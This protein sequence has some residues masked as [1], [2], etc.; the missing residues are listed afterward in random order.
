MAGELTKFLEEREDAYVGLEALLARAERGGL[1]TFSRDELVQLGHLYRLAAAD[2]ARA[3]Y[4]LKSP[5]LSEYLNELVG[6]A[7]H[8]I[9]RRRTPILKSVL[10][11]VARDF[12]ATVRR[13]SGPIL[14]AVTLFVGS[15]LVG[16]MA[17]LA[18]PEW[19]Q[20]V[21]QQPELK[22]IEQSLEREP[23]GLASAIEEDMMP[24][25]S[26]FIISNNVRVS[27]VAAA[28]GI[29]F[30]L[31]TLLAL[32][33]NGF[34]LGVVAVMFL[35]RGGE[36]QLYFFSGV[37]PHGVL[38]LPAICIAGGIGFLLARGLL[39]PGRLSR[40]DAIRR[41]SKNAMKLLGGV[42]LTLVLAGLIE[43]FITPLRAEWVPPAV[44]I[45]LA[46]LLF[47]AFM[48]Y[49][50]RAGYRPEESEPE[51]AELRTTTALRLE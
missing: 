7:H 19:G 1:R 4:V 48:L 29:L 51:Q 42:I 16:G 13:E 9:H 18:D 11:F 46:F 5:L 28:G 6:R 41:E 2:L 49:L 25:A 45:A 40:G 44:K 21:A 23:T 8:L 39:V 3:R 32:V 10:D 14:L 37:L 20:L 30:G 50:T 34:F 27:I 33:Y 12:P 43:G 17:Y 47:I 35:S 15:S 26:A 36:Y 38:E 31:G 22:Q 24:A